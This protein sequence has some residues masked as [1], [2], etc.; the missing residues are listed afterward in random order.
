MGSMSP[1]RYWTSPDGRRTVD[2]DAVVETFEGQ[3]ANLDIDCLFVRFHGG[4]DDTE[5]QDDACDAFLAALKAWRERHIAAA[6]A[7]TKMIGDVIAKGTMP[8]P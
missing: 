2:L 4:G 6:V 1:S 5:I 7:Y 8:T 3:Q